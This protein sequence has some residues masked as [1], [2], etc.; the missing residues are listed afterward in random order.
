MCRKRAL[1]TGAS[2]GLGAHLADR[3][4]A[5]G[6]HVIGLGRRPASDCC[7]AAAIEYIQADL[8]VPEVIDALPARIGES[9]DLIVH[10][11]V[12][13]PDFD[14]TPALAEMET[15]FRVNTFAP[16]QLTLGLLEAKPEDKFCSCIVLNS[17]SIYH[18]D[19]RS[20]LYAAS[21]AALRVLTAALASACRSRNASVS[22]LLLG[23]LADPKKV[24][25][26]RRVAEKKGVTE[27]DITKVFLRKSNPDLV[28]DTLID[29]E[30]CFR[31]V[32]YV[33]SLG[34][35]ANGMVCK[36]DGGSSG[37]LI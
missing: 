33:V 2:H 15:V 37:S 12:S 4:D 22:T 19:H 16:Y 10:N 29:L 31:S 25:G 28:I 6:W 13:Y 36:L 30:S 7:G 20:G 1:I 26:L 21:K 18:A 3:L 27:E 23:P 35:I 11:A 32:I 17:E 14:A 34:R 8:S 9:P 24:E 5:E